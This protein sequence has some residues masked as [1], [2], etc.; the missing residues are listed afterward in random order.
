MLASPDWLELLDW[1]TLL[2]VVEV[3]SSPSYLFFLFFILF[4][5]YFVAAG[6]RAPQ[7]ENLAGLGAEVGQLVRQV[8]DQTSNRTVQAPNGLRAEEILATYTSNNNNNV[9]GNVLVAQALERVN[10]RLDE[11]LERAESTSRDLQQNTKVIPKR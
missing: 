6:N 2:S 4:C 5:V 11:A 3:H 1:W 7:P 9:S 8:I 10:R